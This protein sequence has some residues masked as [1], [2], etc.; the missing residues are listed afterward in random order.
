[1]Q[2]IIN[3]DKKHL[4]QLRILTCKT[5]MAEKMARPPMP[6]VGAQRAYANQLNKTQQQ[7]QEETRP[8]TC[9][10]LA[11]G[12]T[13][14]HL[15]GAQFM[16]RPLTAAGLSTNRSVAGDRFKAHPKRSA[17][18]TNGGLPGLVSRKFSPEMLERNQHL[19]PAS[20]RPGYKSYKGNKHLVH[21]MDPA[22]TSQ[23][24]LSSSSSSPGLRSVATPEFVSTSVHDTGKYLADSA[25][26]SN[27][28]GTTLD[29]KHARK[30]CHTTLRDYN[31]NPIPS[32]Y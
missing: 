30:A 8:S 1:M 23:R 24:P 19:F 20:L 22:E 31:G 13:L 27:Y 6:I 5:P 3:K 15:Q 26:S 25:S 7:Q 18:E 2:S 17:G 28:F 21:T 14:L 11:S 16:A 9:S 32:T 29:Q 4:Q 10:S 12:S